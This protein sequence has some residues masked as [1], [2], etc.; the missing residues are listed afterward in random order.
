MQTILDPP[1]GGFVFAFNSFR[2]AIN[3]SN[4]H[5]IIVPERKR[6][7]DGKSISAVNDISTFFFFFSFCVPFVLPLTPCVDIACYCIFLSRD[8]GRLSNSIQFV[9]L[10]F[11]FSLGFVRRSLSDPDPDNLHDFR[12]SVDVCVC[13]SLSRWT[14]NL[15]TVMRDEESNGKRNETQIREKVASARLRKNT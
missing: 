12:T 13:A 15:W 7:K 1:S 5:G 14:G 4:V 3:Y 11:S 8:T 10:R 6:K 9:V 2:A